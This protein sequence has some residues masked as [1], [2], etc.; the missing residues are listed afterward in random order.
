MTYAAP[1]DIRNAVAPDGS[2]VGT[3]AELDDEQLQTHLQRAEDLVNGYTDVRFSSGNVP[4]I[5]KD[6]EISLAAF[7]ATL[8]YRKG[9]ELSET[10]PVYLAY[11]DA[12]TTL[13]GIKAGSVN[14]ETPTLDTDVSPQRRRP[15]VN[16]AWRNN[17]EMFGMEEFGIHVTSGSANEGYRVTDDPDLANS[18][19]A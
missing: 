13:K 12:Q 18:G 6:L 1:A 9:K 4:G 8:A 10:H 7:Y 17:A 15:K 19:F 2:F 16:N 3:C 5:V 11:Q 14:F